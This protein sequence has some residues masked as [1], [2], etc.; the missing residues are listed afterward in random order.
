MRHSWQH[1]CISDVVLVLYPELAE[2]LN[3]WNVI[4][5]EML[6]LGFNRDKIKITTFSRYFIPLFEFVPSLIFGSLNMLWLFDIRYPLHCLISFIYSY[7]PHICYAVEDSKAL[8]ML[9]SLQ[10]GFLLMRSHLEKNSDAP[11]RQLPVKKIHL[12]LIKLRQHAKYCGDYLATQQLV[13]I[14]MTMHTT[15]ASFFVLV[16]V[17]SDLSL[18]DSTEELITLAF[19]SILPAFGMSRLYVKIWMAV[20]EQKIAS[21]LNLEGLKQEQEPFGSDYSKEVLTGNFQAV[22]KSSDGGFLQ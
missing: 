5:D 16:T 13:T 14:L 1:I 21:I 2:W 9:K 10:V 3:N 4:E 17:L 6:Q 20:R 11:R 7:L 22:D 19:T 8:L 12:L 15:A 18:G